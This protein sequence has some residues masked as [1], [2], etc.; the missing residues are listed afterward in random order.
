MMFLFFGLSVNAQIGKASHK[1]KAHQ[2][3]NFINE[4]YGDQA[5]KVIFSN[6]NLYRTFKKLILERMEIV[7]KSEMKGKKV[8][9]ITENGMFDTY[10]SNVS[11]DDF[12]DVNNFNPLKYKLVFFDASS[13]QVYEIDNTDYL[14]IIKPQPKL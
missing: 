10:N 3:D 6:K 13:Y 12:F 14:L 9:K 5:Q 1:F 4:V 11:H 7:R 2:V 8:P